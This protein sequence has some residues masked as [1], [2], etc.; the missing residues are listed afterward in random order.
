[1]PGGH[2][3]MMA[4]LTPGGLRRMK[5]PMGGRPRGSTPTRGVCHPNRATP[6]RAA[7]RLKILT[8]VARPMIGI[9]IHNISERNMKYKNHND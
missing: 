5:T 4:T 2:R 8:H 7:C 6:M 1:M 3:L 9:I